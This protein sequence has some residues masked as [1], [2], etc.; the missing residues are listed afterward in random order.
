MPNL[1]AGFVSSFESIYRSA[2]FNPGRSF[3]N[4]I[5]LES[6]DTPTY[7]ELIETSPTWFVVASCINGS[8]IPPLLAA[9]VERGFSL[10]AP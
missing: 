10:S 7:F 5:Y 8:L 2:V 3:M 6:I 1:G 4:R 9:V